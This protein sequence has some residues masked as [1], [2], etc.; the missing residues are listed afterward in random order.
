V[1][2]AE[3]TQLRLAK[4]EGGNKNGTRR[5]FSVVYVIKGQAL[6]RAADQLQ[7]IQSTDQAETDKP[8]GTLQSGLDEIVEAVIEC[9]CGLGVRASAIGWVG[10][11]C[12]S[13][14]PFVS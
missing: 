9:R 2:S 11:P 10:C 6:T 4:K 13:S 3:V 7:Q 12:W 8:V 1:E 5:H 14:I